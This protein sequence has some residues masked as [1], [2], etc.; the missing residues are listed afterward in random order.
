MLSAYILIQCQPKAVKEIK[1]VVKKHPDLKAY[2]T[3]GTYDVVI[4]WTVT[5]PDELAELVLKELHPIQ[6]IQHTET[7]ICIEQLSKTDDSKK[8]T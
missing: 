4:N 6:G 5:E 2:V 1:K 7:L 8:E 3:F